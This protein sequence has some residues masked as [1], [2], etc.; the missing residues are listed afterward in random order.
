MS[1]L[2]GNTFW[3]GFAAAECAVL[4]ALSTAPGD[5]ISP[6]ISEQFIARLRDR[7]CVTECLSHASCRVYG[8]GVYAV[9]DSA[10]NRCAALD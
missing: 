10:F 6:L 7:G 5:C 9:G 4:D 1:R 2:K 3:W 8:V